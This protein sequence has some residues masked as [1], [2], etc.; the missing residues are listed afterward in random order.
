MKPPQELAK[1]Q[2]NLKRLEQKMMDNVGLNN[3]RLFPKISQ[4]GRSMAMLQAY[5]GKSSRSIFLDDLSNL[6]LHRKPIYIYLIHF[7]FP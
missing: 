6:M 1:F 4:K 3:E 5:E 7:L 2:N